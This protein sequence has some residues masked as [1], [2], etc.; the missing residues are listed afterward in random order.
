MVVGE[1]GRCLAAERRP[2][3]GDSAVRGGAVVAG[4]ALHLDRERDGVG[5]EPSC[6]PACR[7]APSSL[8][9]RCQR[10]QAAH[11][12]PRHVGGRRLQVV[13]HIERVHDA[14]HQRDVLRYVYNIVGAV[15][16][17]EPADGVVGRAG[18][19]AVAVADAL[20]ADAPA[21]ETVGEVAV[22]DDVGA[23]RAGGGGGGG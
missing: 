21:V 13:V 17:E 9:R 8:R 10:V 4:S 23:G 22:D 19:A 14:G 12:L 15:D 16:R 1:C 2:S 3:R 20:G 18:V 6:R 7:R 5:G 11:K